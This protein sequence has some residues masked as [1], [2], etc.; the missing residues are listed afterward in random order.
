[1]FKQ[2]EDEG[3]NKQGDETLFCASWQVTPLT[4]TVAAR[5][6]ISCT[7]GLDKDVTEDESPHRLLGLNNGPWLVLLFGG[8]VE[9]F[10]CGTYL[11]EG[12]LQGCGLGLTAILA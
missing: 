5:Q 4:T 6:P 12:G 7:L 3:G 1:M 9:P 2:P 11:A 10:E 8:A